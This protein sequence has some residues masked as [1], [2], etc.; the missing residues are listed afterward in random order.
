MKTPL[1]PG[2]FLEAPGLYVGQTGDRKQQYIS[3]EHAV[4]CRE[5]PESCFFGTAMSLLSCKCAACVFRP[6][7]FPWV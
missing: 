5:T 2:T 1:R 4:I 6:V 7:S 3:S